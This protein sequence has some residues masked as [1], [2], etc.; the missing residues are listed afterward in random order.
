MYID[1]ANGPSMWVDTN[2]EDDHA[3]GGAKAIA[4]EYF[5]MM[6]AGVATVLYDRQSI[7][8]SSGIPESLGDNGIAIV[9][10]YGIGPGNSN[11]FL[12]LRDKNFNALR[13]YE[14]DTASGAVMR[15]FDIQGVTYLDYTEIERV[16]RPGVMQEV[17]S[18]TYDP[19]TIQPELPDDE[20]N[21]AGRRVHADEAT[22]L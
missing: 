7:V 3:G 18:W 19:R 11:R 17:L 10:A 15:G 5:V 9:G 8:D 2:P 21:E 22:G 4:I 12:A 14:L 16:D 1:T 6:R 20:L 13:V